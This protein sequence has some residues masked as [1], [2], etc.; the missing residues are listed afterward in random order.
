MGCFILIIFRHRQIYRFNL[1]AKIQLF[2][3]K[4]KREMN[5]YAKKGREK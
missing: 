1:F 2:S 3:E 5:I 4:S